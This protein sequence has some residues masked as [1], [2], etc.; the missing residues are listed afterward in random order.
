MKILSDNSKDFYL[1]SSLLK[2]YDNKINHD[3]FVEVLQDSSMISLRMIDWFVTKYSKKNNINYEIN[4][5]TF[6]VYTNYKSQLK[7]FS[8]KSIDPFCRRDRLVLDK[9]SVSIVTTIGQMNFFKWA[10][11][12]GVL[13]Y[14]CDNF[15][16][17]E[18][19][20]KSYSKN[21]NEKRKLKK[22][23]N[24]NKLDDEAII[25]DIKP[26]I[27]SAVISFD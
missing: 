22:I 26:P 18:K 14:I 7:V 15:E 27:Y 2:Y 3:A 25:S 13:K 17:L 1:Y 20:M 21:E 24:I 8:K 4:G 6:E 16:I 11:D 10:I 12:N 19:E 23:S 5:K 9:H